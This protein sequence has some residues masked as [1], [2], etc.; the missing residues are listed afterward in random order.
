MMKRKYLRSNT[1][2]ERRQRQKNVAEILEQK[3]AATTA[4]I[5][6]EEADKF[7]HYTAVT[8]ARKQEHR[9][10]RP[11]ALGPHRKTE[12]MDRKDKA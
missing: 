7:E 4:A 6:N 2:R 12:N 1:R 10:Q 5:A 9:Q 3:H 11:S 8:V